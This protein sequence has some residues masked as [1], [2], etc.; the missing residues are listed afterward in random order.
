M[1]TPLAEPITWDAPL[2]D[3][4]R[5]LD[6]VHAK[7][8]AERAARKARR[9]ADAG[10]FL[11]DGDWNCRGCAAGYIDYSAE[12]KK[13]VSAGATLTMPADHHLSR[14][15]LDVKARIGAENIHMTID[16]DGARWGG[17]CQD[18][19]LNKAADGTRTVVFTFND[20]IKE[21]ECIQIWS[22]PFLMAALQWPK[23]FVLAGPARYMLK[24]T[25]FLNL[26]R[27]HGNFW[28]LPDNPLDMATWFEGVIPW[29]WSIAVTA[30][31]ILLDDSQWCVIDSR[32]KNFMELAT[33]ILED[34]GL[35]ITTRR[36]LNGD[37]TPDGWLGPLRN[38]QLIIDIVDKSGVYD[39]TATGGTIFGGMLRTVTTIG[40]NLVD[41]IVTSVA[42]PAEP[43]QYSVSK[44]MGTAPQ[45]PWVVLRDGEIT[46][47]ESASYTWQP[48][49]VVQ[50]NA[51]GR[52]APGVN[53]AISMGVQLM[54]TLVGAAFGLQ[55]AGQ[56][57]DTAIAPLYADVLLA[58]GSVKSPVRASQ[59]GWSHYHEGWAQG[60][61]IAWAL[62]GIV[63]IRE[64]FYATRSRSTCTVKINS[65]GPYLIGDQ[66]QGHF[67]LG[68]RV[69]VLL[70]GMPDGAYNVAQVSGLKL[71]ASRDS[72]PGWDVTTGDP[73]A[74]ESP[75]A[76]LLNQSK[77]VFAAL[78]NLGVWA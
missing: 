10:I 34:A 43:A 15:G 72:A 35:M 59:L 4:D 36:W 67:F 53:S 66:G 63:A 68:D 28:H 9:E 51:G 32:F 25:L 76:R 41:D 46:P 71:S 20:D 50:I 74:A 54:G 42:S 73:R 55:T 18:V 2:E 22:N 65:S 5:H 62:S 3:L 52:S 23:S 39:Q 60:G 6:E 58:F 37:P 69:G 31:N 49:T 64:A 40:D 48:A 30:D 19:T 29:D 57:L 24:L 38:G 11:Y 77:T 16:K 8:Q 26:I 13:N 21:L 1:T 70:T 14:W 27:L 47:I 12:W 17:R 56:L 61:E 75:I 33:P 7:I 44:W 78:K 45:Q